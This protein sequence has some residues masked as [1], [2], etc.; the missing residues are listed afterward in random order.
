[1]GDTPT[2]KYHWKEYKDMFYRKMHPKIH[3]DLLNLKYMQQQL[4]NSTDKT[5]VVTGNLCEKMVLN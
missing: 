1:M 4:G 5:S 3:T 2:K